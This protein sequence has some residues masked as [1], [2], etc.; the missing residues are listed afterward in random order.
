MG[1]D[2]RSPWECQVPVVDIAS[3]DIHDG[4]KWRFNSRSQFPYQPVIQLGRILSLGWRACLI[5]LEVLIVQDTPSEMCIPRNLGGDTFQ[6]EPDYTG[7]LGLWTCLRACRLRATLPSSGHHSVQA[8]RHKGHVLQSRRICQSSQHHQGSLHR[9]GQ[10]GE[11]MWPSPTTQRF[12]FGPRE[13][14]SFTLSRCRKPTRS[15]P[16]RSSCTWWSFRSTEARCPRWWRVPKTERG[17]TRSPRTRSPTRDCA[18]T[19]FERRR[20]SNAPSGRASNAPSGRV[21]RR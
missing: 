2:E 19:T 11:V 15:G 6:R 17:L 7:K 9:A 8:D 14:I 13:Q 1:K 3:P 10:S 16:T 21:W 12:V 5:R 4:R 20:D 18:G